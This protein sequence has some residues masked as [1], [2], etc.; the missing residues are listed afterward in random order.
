MK[1]Y[2]EL[3]Q[4]KIKTTQEAGFRAKPI[5]APLFGWQKHIVNWAIQ[6]GRCALFEDCGLGK[7]AQQ[8]EWARQVCEHTGGNVLI[9]TPLAVAEQTI[10]EGKKFGITAHHAKDASTLKSGIN[11]TNYEKLDLFDGVEFAGVVLDESSILKNFS[12]KTRI[13]LTERFSSTPYRLCC[14]A[15]PSPNDF[16]EIGQHADFL[17]IC[18]PAQMLA[19]YFINDTFDTGTWRLKGHAEKAF[20]KWLG[21]WAACVSRPSDI[22]FSDEGYILPTL[23]L[24]TILVEVDERGEGEELCAAGALLT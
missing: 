24:D 12:G 11:V 15:T 14:T 8:L 16:T 3:I 13:A 7:T 1:S 2:D 4:A 18:S 20:W 19:T 9:L 21:S 5:D 10:K 17:G 6:Q 23:N 22:G